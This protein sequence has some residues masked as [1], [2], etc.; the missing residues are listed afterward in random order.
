YLN[1]EAAV[2]YPPIETS[3]YYYK[4]AKNYWLSVN[5]LIMHKRIELQIKAFERLPEENLIIVGSYEQ[6]RHFK[7][8]ADYIKS[9]KP[10]N[11]KIISW[12]ENKKLIELY[13]ECKGF[14]TTA[15]EEDFG[16]TPLEAMAAGKPVIAPNE[17]GFKESII[18]GVTGRLIDNIDPEKILQAIIEIRKKPETYKDA[19]IKQARN[20]DTKIF[21]KKIKEEVK[22]NSNIEL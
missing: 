18:N 2:I 13:A 10:K 1:R 12:L 6:S 14:I 22:I 4:K 11:V 3:K 9:I 19:C 15:K 16:M 8:Y 7:K 20:F 17:G 5:R 21:I